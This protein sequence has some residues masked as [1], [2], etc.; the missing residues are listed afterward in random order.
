MAT[1]ETL[2]EIVRHHEARFSLLTSIAERQLELLGEVRRDSRQTHR[3]WVNLSRKY[4]WLDERDLPSDDSPNSY[5][6]HQRD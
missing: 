5:D 2:E 6:L 3:L 1:L 4:G